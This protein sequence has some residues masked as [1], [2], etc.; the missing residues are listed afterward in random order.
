MK[1][2]IFKL[3]WP[4]IVVQILAVT[5]IIGFMLIEHYTFVEALYMTTLAITTVGFGEVHKLS[6]SGQIFTTLLLIASWLSLAFALAS[7]TQFAVS[8]EVQKYFK[9]KKIMN[10]VNALSNHVILCG[11]GRNGKQAAKTLQV[12]NIPFVVIDKS[13]ELIEKYK[14]S[15][16]EITF[17]AGDATQDDVLIQANITKARSLITALPTDTEN[18]FIV[19][20][21][22][23]LAPALHI[24]SRAGTSQ[25]MANLQKAGANNVIMPEAIGG[26]HMATLVSKPDVIEFVDYISG[27]EGESIHIESV[28]FESLPPQ[29]HNKTLMEVMNWRPT[30]VTAIGIKNTQ[31]KFILNPAPDTVISQGIKLLVLGDR[32][33]IDA[34][35]LNLDA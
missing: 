30:G 28:G 14:I 6:T 11:F 19:L 22:R 26:T 9:N 20:T 23:N 7:V 12:H 10:T 29:L 5:G 3:I 34:M 33:Q 1:R 31:G 2:W 8:G 27:E 24:V 15:H 21:A 25:G 18:V 4:F 17:L 35:K 16:P 32:K 13:N